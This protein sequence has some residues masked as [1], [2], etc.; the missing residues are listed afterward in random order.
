MKAVVIREPYKMDLA[1]VPTPTPSANQLLVKVAYAGICG[2]DMHIWHGKNSRV[3]YPLIMGHEL[4]GV[5]TMVGK[6]C[7]AQWKVGEKI[8]VNPL[9]SCG[10]CDACRRGHWHVCHKLGLTGI[11]VDG[12]FAEYVTINASQ[13]IRVPEDVSLDIAA[14][15]EPFAVGIHA[16]HRGGVCLGD[17][18]VI[19]GGGP[20]GLMVALA[21]KAA[22]AQKIII[23]DVND[24]R[25]SVIQKLGFVALNG[26]DSDLKNKVWENTDKIG[27]DVV[28]EAAATAPTSALMTGLARTRGTIVMVGVHRQ[29]TGV[30]LQDVNLRELTIVGS[31]VYRNVDFNVAAD[32]LPK[33]P[34][35]AKIATH[36]LSLEEH[37][38]AFTAMESQTDSLKILLHP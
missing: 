17:R 13:A 1:D 34:D 3:K 4:S 37:A 6:A 7:E 28:F 18:V 27:A 30:D 2:S 26:K 23:I 19:Q 29:L 21:A 5:I 16:V 8:I 11:D 36:R 33:T 22:G 9:L 10:V 31:R 14:L 38:A 15:V 20:I 25:L 35:L 32:L 12:A 24:F